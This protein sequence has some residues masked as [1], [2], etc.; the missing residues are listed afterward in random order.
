MGVACAGPAKHRWCHLGGGP[1]ILKRMWQFGS[2]RT[3]AGVPVYP[4]NVSFCI[5][6]MLP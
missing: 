3:R 2:L 5:L 6:G 1:V 4:V